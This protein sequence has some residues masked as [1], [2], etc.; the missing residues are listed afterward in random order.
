MSNLT[1]EIVIESPSARNQVLNNRTDEQSLANLNKAKSL[2]MAVWNSTSL[3]TT[4]QLADYYGVPKKTV[5]N[6]VDRHRDEF[7][8]ELKN[9]TGKELQDAVFILRIPSKTSQ[10]L[11]FTARGALRVGLLLTQSEVAKNVRNVVLN[12]VESVP[13]ILVGSLYPL[14]PGERYVDQKLNEEVMLLQ[15]GRETLDDRNFV[16]QEFLNEAW[17]ERRNQVRVIMESMCK[18]SEQTKGTFTLKQ[19]K[20]I[21][22]FSNI[23]KVEYVFVTDV[24]ELMVQRCLIIGI[25][26]DNYEKMVVEFAHFIINFDK[27]SINRLVESLSWC[28]EENLLGFSKKE[29]VP[30]RKEISDLQPYMDEKLSKEFDTLPMGASLTDIIKDGKRVV[31]YVSKTFIDD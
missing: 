5:N 21:P 23:Y 30:W 12:V 16:I 18:I 31:A 6:L 13:Q 14:K 24:V 7:G 29:L 20:T 3:A 28:R 10:A 19:L 1:H 22:A 9:L 8:T 27:G 26:R 4:E 15:P 2:I 11:V 17:G 25:L